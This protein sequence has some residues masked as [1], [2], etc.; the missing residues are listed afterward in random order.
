MLLYEMIHTQA[1]MENIGALWPGLGGGAELFF[2]SCLIQA[3]EPVDREQNCW[4]C[5]RFFRKSR[6]KSAALPAQGKDFS[7]QSG[8]KRSV[9]TAFEPMLLLPQRNLASHHASFCRQPT[10]Q[11]LERRKHSC[12]FAAP[13]DNKNS[14][15]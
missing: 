1:L 6:R 10:Q 8:E 2:A 15:R 13:P 9:N 11:S 12:G 14:T 7:T 3:L 5:E 4:I